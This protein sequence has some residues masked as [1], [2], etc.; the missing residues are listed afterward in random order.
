MSAL[1]V[2]RLVFPSISHRHCHGFI[3]RLSG[4]RVIQIASPLRWS[5][6]SHVSVHGPN[7]V[8]VR[9]ADEGRGGK[10]DGRTNR[11]KRCGGEQRGIEADTATR[12]EGT[13][14]R[15]KGVQAGLMCRMP[16]DAV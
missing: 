11:E 16:I 3:C 8:M 14:G 2:T 4:V 6:H 10:S 9:R 7:M 1:R 15:A 13:R 12:G 5:T